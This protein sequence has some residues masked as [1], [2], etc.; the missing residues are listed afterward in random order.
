MSFDKIFD[1]TAGVF[2]LFFIMNILPRSTLV[3]AAG[4][5][6]GIS[7]ALCG[8]FA[9]FSLMEGAAFSCGKDDAVFY[10]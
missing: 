1:L 2:F 3:S 5:V 4:R 9:G 10:L 6:A 8:T 7:P